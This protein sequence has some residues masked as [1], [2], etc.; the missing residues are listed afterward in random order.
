MVKKYF[1][2][3]NIV[4]HYLNEIHVALAKVETLRVASKN[5]LLF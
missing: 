2:S 4:Y 5:A 1:S 3:Y